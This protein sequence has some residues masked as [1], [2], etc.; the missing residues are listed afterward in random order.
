MKKLLVLAAGI[1]QV[2]VIKKAREMGVFVVAA[3]G[4]PDAV[5]LQLADKPVVANITSEE[6]MLRVAREERVG[7]S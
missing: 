2:P 6:D 1:L 4:N 5:G 7:P 3:D